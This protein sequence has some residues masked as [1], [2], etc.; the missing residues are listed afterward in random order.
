MS[1]PV[2]VVGSLNLDLV[3]RP[4][5]AP[6]AGET[7]FA[8]QLERF[9]GGKGGNQA[10]AAARL[11]A[12]VA[13]VGCVG[14][15]GF[16]DELVANLVAEGVQV[17]A[18]ARSAQAGTGTALITVDATGQNR[19]IVVSGANNEVTPALVDRH[20][21]LIQSAAVVLL[22]LEVPV[23]TCLH[24]AEIAHAAGV[25]VI[26]DPAP[27]PAEPLPARLRELVWLV[28]PNETEAAVLTGMPVEGRQGVPEVAAALAGQGYRQ[29]IVKAGGSGAYLFTGGTG[30]WFDSF[31]VPVVDTTAAGD[32][33][34]GGLA[35]ALAR[36]LSMEEAITWGSAAGALAVTR[37]G[38]QPSMGTLQELQTLLNSRRDRS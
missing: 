27:A 25:P 5:R 36:G 23:S 28:T 4:H 19:I 17:G 24:V 38:A 30:H 6:A 31:Q 14:T 18:V 7:V 16:G 34:A 35:A 8:P 20:L 21:D 22:Q 2:V 3:V 10:V 12:S 9:P 33:F 26:L 15:D 13:M 37:P 29:V 1:K 11:G 32:A